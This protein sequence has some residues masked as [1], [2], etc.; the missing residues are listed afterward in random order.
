[1]APG[2]GNRQGRMPAARAGDHAAGGS[3]ERRY[4]TGWAT[5]ES[6]E[7]AG[8]FRRRQPCGSRTG[9][10]GQSVTRRRSGR[11][12]VEVYMS[13]RLCMAIGSTDSKNVTYDAAY[14]VRWQCCRRRSGESQRHAFRA[15]CRGAGMA[16]QGRDKA[17]IARGRAGL[18]RTK[19]ML[20]SLSRRARS[21]VG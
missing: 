7:T 1:M 18:T 8:P 16:E 10:Q 11:H 19:P 13:R 17:R 5:P 14:R 2:P 15:G 9:K 3:A 12:W 6:T 4:A 20:L 21:S